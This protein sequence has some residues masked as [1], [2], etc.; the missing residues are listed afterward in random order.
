M[1]RGMVMVFLAGL[2]ASCGSGSSTDQE[3][4]A[5]SSSISDEVPGLAFQKVAWTVLGEVQRGSSETVPLGVLDVT[6][7]QVCAPGSSP[8]RMV[9]E[10]LPIPQRA[11]EAVAEHGQPVRFVSVANGVCPDAVWLGFAAAR[12]LGRD[13]F[14]VTIDLVDTRQPYPRMELGREYMLVCEERYCAVASIRPGEEP[15]VE[16]KYA[17]EAECEFENAAEEPS[18]DGGA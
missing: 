1:V 11:R 8:C 18:L 10:E 9:S 16:L 4:E 12:V 2:L 14:A 7:R 5:E 13:S 17:S 6:R 15:D 3:P